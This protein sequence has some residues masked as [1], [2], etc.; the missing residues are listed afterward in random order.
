MLSIMRPSP[1]IDELLAQIRVHP[2][3]LVVEVHGAPSLKVGLA[4]AGLKD[5]DLSGVEGGLHQ[6]PT[7]AWR[8]GSGGPTAGVRGHSRTAGPLPSA[9]RSGAILTAV[10]ATP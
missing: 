4:E 5:S 2:D 6:M 10:Q 1:A 9:R 7:G 3:H 8:D